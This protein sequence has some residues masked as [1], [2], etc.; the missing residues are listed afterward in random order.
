M[1]SVWK[2]KKN[3]IEE[4]SPLCFLTCFFL[5]FLLLVLPPDVILPQKLLNLS[6]S[7]LLLLFVWSQI[8]SL[9]SL[10]WGHLYSLLPLAWTVCSWGDWRRPPPPPLLLFSFSFFVVNLL[11]EL[12][13][14]SITN[15]GGKLLP[16]SPFLLGW[17]SPPQIWISR[18]LLEPS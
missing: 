3:N 7:V 2:K 9:R 8:Q 5:L 11:K 13:S 18:L 17:F 10:C 4:L 16:Y 15:A 6:L 14:F 1:S 12:S